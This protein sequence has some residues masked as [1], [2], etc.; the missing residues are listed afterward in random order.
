MKK[1]TKIWLIS[2][3]FLLIV[4]VV[5][6]FAINPIRGFDVK[7]YTYQAQENGYIVQIDTL[8]GRISVQ[9]ESKPVQP[10]SPAVSAMLDFLPYVFITV[11]VLGVI[12]F[13]F[14]TK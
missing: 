5:S 4:E 14:G 13:T 1:S 8:T 7:E 11:I 9:E 3:A 12:S 2:L 10:L 6:L